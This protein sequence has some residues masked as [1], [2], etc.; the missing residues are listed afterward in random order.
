[1]TVIAWTCGGN[2]VQLA[3]DFNQWKPEPLLKQGNYFYKIVS[4]PN[5]LHHYKF[6]V[7]G[8]WV[9]DIAQPHDIDDNGYWNN[10]IQI[11]PA[12]KPVPK[13]ADLKKPQTQPQTQPQQSSK[14]KQQQAERNNKKA[15]SK[16]TKEEKGK[17]DTTVKPDSTE[18]PDTT[19]KPDSTEKPDSNV[20]PDNTSKPPKKQVSI[21]TLEIVGSDDD[22]DMVKL[23][24]FV[25]SFSKPGLKWEGSAIKDHVYG[26]KK[27]EIICQAED[28]VSVEE[29]VCAEL[30]KNE[31]LVGS[32][33]LLSFSC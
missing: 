19:V 3:G 27:L 14:P 2:E 20:K 5:G 24:E 32:A 23:E 31:K 28:D 13:K 15:K 17:P 22:T 6:V 29:E 12:E 18:K 10:C 21:I 16:E 9:Y 7:D 1:M 4:L 26:L 8:A 30:A 25:R 11:G 33:Q